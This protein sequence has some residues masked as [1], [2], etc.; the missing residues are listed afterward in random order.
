MRRGS[1]SSARP[2]T[3]VRRGSRAGAVAPGT[4]RVSGSS[5]RRRSR[6]RSSGAHSSSRPP[7]AHTS[8]RRWRASTTSSSR[9]PSRRRRGVLDSRASSEHPVR[10]VDVA[11]PVELLRGRRRHPRQAGVGVGIGPAGVGEQP[12]HRSEVPGDLRAPVRG[13]GQAP[14][15]CGSA[16]GEVGGLP[17]DGPEHGRRR[18]AAARRGSSLVVPPRGR[19]RGHDVR[20]SS[21]TA[22]PVRASRRP[23]RD[24]TPSLGKTW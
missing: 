15:A 4:R 10:R 9:R 24:V 2:S 11:V 1:R 20:R 16:G 3:A 18:S 17:Q 8:R 5:G 23:A 21:A 12:G 7:D 13:T 19:G 14:A 6:R 22:R